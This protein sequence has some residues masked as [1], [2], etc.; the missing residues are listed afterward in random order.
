MSNQGNRRG[1]SGH[2]AGED[3]PRARLPDADV[4]IIRELHE[5]HGLGYGTL[6]E[7]FETLREPCATEHACVSCQGGGHV[8]EITKDSISVVSWEEMNTLECP[9]CKGTGIMTCLACKGKGYEPAVTLDGLLE[10][11][12]TIANV[13]LVHYTTIDEW[14]CYIWQ[15]KLE[16]EPPFKNR[17]GKGPTPYEAALRAMA[18]TVEV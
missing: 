8:H 14:S 11:A 9:R 12:R 2:R 3:H 10:V 15:Y 16:N 18:A 6:A 13:S 7:K 5:Q 17:E 1:P 4:E